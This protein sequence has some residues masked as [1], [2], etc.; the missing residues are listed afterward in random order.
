MNKV[1]ETETKTS[2]TTG[3]QMLKT[4][5]S[6]KQKHPKKIMLVKELAVTFHI[7]S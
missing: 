2:K 7:N 6:V 5:K 3:S 1:V 4:L